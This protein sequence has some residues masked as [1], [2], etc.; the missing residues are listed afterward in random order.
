MRKAWRHAVIKVGMAARPNAMA[1]GGAGA[2]MAALRR[3]TWSTPQ[4]DAL[5]TTDG[6]ILYFGDG[7]NAEGGHRTDP[8]SM[9]HWLLDAYDRVVL[10]SEVAKHITCLGGGRGYGREKKEKR[11]LEGDTAYYGGFGAEATASRVWR[12][13]ARGMSMRRGRSYL[14]FAC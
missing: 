5:R 11:S 12:G 13:A 4:P 7:Q 2:M 10:H 14:G 9:R 3:L 8:K 6:Y 1:Q